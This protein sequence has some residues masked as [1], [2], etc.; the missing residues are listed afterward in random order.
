MRSVGPP[1]R[2]PACPRPSRVVGWPARWRWRARFPG[3]R[4]S[5]PRPGQ[6]VGARDAHTLAA[7]ESGALSEWRATLIARESACL[8]VEDRRLLDAEVCADVGK[9]EGMGDARIVAAAKE[10]AAR[11]DAQAVV[12]RAAK[13]EAD[14][15]VT[16]RPAPDCMT[17]VTALLPVAQGVGVYAA[18][19]R[20]ADTTVDDRSRG[21][22]MADTLVER[23]TGRPA[24]AS[25]PV[26]LNLVMSDQALW[27]QDNAP[28]VLDGHGPIPASVAQ[29]LVRGGWP[30]TGRW[31][32]CGGC[33]GT[34]RAGRWWRW[35]RDR[36]CSRR[37][38][39]DSSACGTARV[40]PRTVMRRFGIGITPHRATAAGRPVPPMGWASANGATT[41]KKRRAGAS[42][43]ETKT[44]RTQP[45]SSRPPVPGIGRQRHRYPAH[46]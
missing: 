27:G 8:D 24:D 25:A 1:R 37:G 7:L 42:P 5:A 35:S 29:R 11:L 46:H 30:I 12:D 20:S 32:R 38:W 40:A 15:T 33:I 3:A 6:S 16:I 2:R 13:A 45:T 14:R 36:G 44:V 18:L 39:P 9:L 21:Q 28:A 10:I 31:R 4:R 22:V 41:P 34:P 19:K 23:V 43:R 17:Y 26:A